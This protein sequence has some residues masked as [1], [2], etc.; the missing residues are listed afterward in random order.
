[1]FRF[2]RGFNCGTGTYKRSKDIQLAPISTSSYP[3]LGGLGSRDRVSISNF[4]EVHKSQVDCPTRYGCPFLIT[5]HLMFQ[6]APILFP[7]AWCPH[8]GPRAGRKR[9]NCGTG[10]YKRSKDIQLAPISTSSYPR[11]G[12]FNCGTGTYKRSKD[13]QLAPISTSSYPRLGG[14]GNFQEQPIK[15]RYLGHVTGYQPIRDQ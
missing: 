11:L 4:S 8:S 14:E 7:T 12:G 15:T 5:L 3:R 9:F 1:M 6:S 13:I 10:T 2:S